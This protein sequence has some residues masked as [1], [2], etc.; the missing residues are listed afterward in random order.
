MSSSA[1]IDA[2]F[3][4]PGAA[5]LTTV[6]SGGWAVDYDWVADRVVPSGVPRR[7]A[8][9][10]P[11]NRDLTGVLPGQAAFSGSRY[12]FGPG[13]YL[14][15][16]TSDGAPDGPSTPITQAWGLPA[17][18]TTVD[19]VFGG[20]GAKSGFAYFFRGPDY[21]RYDWSA[22]AVSPGYPKAFGPNWHTTP[23]FAA[24][25]DGS[26]TGRAGFATK[27]Y[28]FRT[29]PV[30]IND[31]GALTPGGRS[32]QTTRYAR[33]DYDSEQFEFTVVDPAAVVAN[34]PGLLPLLDAGTA[35]DLAL[36][37]IGQTLDVLVGGAA[38]PA[39][40]TAFGHHFGTGG[41]PVDPGVVGTVAANFA[42]LRTRFLALPDRLQ[43]TPGLN[44]AA[45]TTQGVLL[46][47]GDQFSSLHGPNGRAAVMIHE[48]VHFTFGAGPDVPEWSGAT[49]GGSTFGEATDPDTGATLGTY[50]SLTTAAALTNP[51]SYAAFAQEIALGSDERFGIARRH[52]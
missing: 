46:E 22:D 52:E 10:A 31:D 24:G 18:W 35:T 40:Q 45:Q 12:I 5:N 41:G 51:S 39:V 1:R 37:W 38:A 33:Y 7:L 21:V 43:W 44:F 34:W 17:A 16:R 4:T 26:I 29:S 8:F 25:I 3:P 11:F 2:A 13:D 49:I 47:I 32:V 20:G 48:M 19:A 27:A 28:L 6:I 14:R 30:T 9:A 50:A 42:T 15:V 36:F 23:D